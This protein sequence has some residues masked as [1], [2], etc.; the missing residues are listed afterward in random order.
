MAILSFKN[1]SKHYS[2]DAIA[3]KE[4]TFSIQPGEFAALAGPSGS[5]K[6]TILNLA[7]GLD[8][9]SEGSVLFSG[10]ELTSLTAD[11][12]AV[13]RRRSFG[14]VFQSYN[15][16]PVLTALENVEYPLALNHVSADERQRRAK[17]ALEEVGLA[18]FCRRFPSQLS[19]GQQ[20]RVAIA[21]AIV[22]QPQ[23]V[24]A[25]EP[26][27]NLDSGT[28]EKLLLLFRKLNETKK[29]TFLFSSHDPMV[30]GVAKRILQIRDGRIQTDVWVQTPLP[31][32][33]KKTAR[34]KDLF[35]QSEAKGEVV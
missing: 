13:L 26:T 1:V 8:R 21:R 9:P 6:T 11:R 20:Q 12:L 30:L 27:A 28:A 7:A 29:I 34:P 31:P 22:A 10:K 14:F 15:L 16:F 3:L 25:D 19:G 33:P 24:F 18:E 4:V 32:E 23:I 35:L 5:G 2:T 17:A